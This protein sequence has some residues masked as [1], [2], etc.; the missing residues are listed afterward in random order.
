MILI[1]IQEEGKMIENL[2]Q[3]IKNLKNMISLI[4]KRHRERNKRN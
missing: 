2:L 4:L 1:M 3:K